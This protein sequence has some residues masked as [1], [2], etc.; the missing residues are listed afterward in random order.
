MCDK[1]CFRSGHEPDE[2]VRPRSP[3]ELFELAQKKQ[4]A[5]EKKTKTNGTKWQGDYLR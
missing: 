3:E 4:E 1:A 2:D 5:R